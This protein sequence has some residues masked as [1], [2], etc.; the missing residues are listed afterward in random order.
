MATRKKT[1]R[2]LTVPL[3]V[4]ISPEL[5]DAVDRAAIA[6]ELPTNEWVAKVLAKEIGNNSLGVIPR[7]TMGRPRKMLAES[8]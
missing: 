3:H 4:P 7:K 1:V 6:A 5:K 8:N 2:K